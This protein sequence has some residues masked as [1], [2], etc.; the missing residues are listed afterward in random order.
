LENLKD[1]VKIENPFQMKSKPLLP[2]R[3]SGS[4]TPTMSVVSEMGLNRMWRHDIEV[5]VVRCERG[6]GE[7]VFNF[8]VFLNF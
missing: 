7:R 3:F 1:V 8:E 4:S 6:R 2:F 5:V